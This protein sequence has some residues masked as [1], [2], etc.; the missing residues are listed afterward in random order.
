VTWLLWIIV[1]VD[2]GMRRLGHE[3]NNWFLPC[4]VLDHW[5]TGRWGV[6]REKTI[7]KVD[8]ALIRGEEALIDK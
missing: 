4:V 6:G 3:T 8:S 1:E 7:G 2:D 5:A